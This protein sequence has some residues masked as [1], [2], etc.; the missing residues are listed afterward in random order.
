MT[1][2]DVTIALIVENTMALFKS[3]ARR[4]RWGTEAFSGTLEVSSSLIAFNTS[5]RSMVR[6]IRPISTETNAATA[7]RRK[8]GAVTW[9]MTCD[10]CVADGVSIGMACSPSRT[11]HMR[12]ASLLR[13]ANWR[14][15]LT[16]QG[17]LV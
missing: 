1:S 6:F 11:D 17:R 3:T 14:L 9:E 10:S 7:P 8:E 2:N 4:F 15:R 16:I 5:N 13:L 12:R